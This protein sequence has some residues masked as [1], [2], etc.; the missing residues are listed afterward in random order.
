MLKLTYQQLANKYKCSVRTIQRHI[1]KAPKKA[2]NLPLQ[3]RLNIIADTT[4]FGRSFGV[5]VLMD[6]MTEKVIYH[7]I[8]K[9]EKDRYYKIAL[10]KLREKGYIIQSITCD[11]RR[12]LLNDFLDTPTQ[13]CHFHQVAIVMRKLRKKHQ[14]LA[15]KELKI[16]VK[17]LKSSTKNE[18]YMRLHHWSKKHKSFLEERADKPNEKGYFPYKHRNVRGSYASLKRYFKYLFTFEDYADLNIEKT[19]NRIEGLFS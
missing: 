4:F 5:L 7:Q 13:M 1:D 8:V 17:T 18:F 15:G 2:L 16:I 14:S 19:T 11:G 10:N 6:S 9:T 3:N 12:G